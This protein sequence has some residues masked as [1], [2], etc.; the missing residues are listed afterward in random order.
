MRFHTGKVAATFKASKEK[1]GFRVACF[2]DAAARF[3]AWQTGTGCSNHGQHPGRGNTPIG[4]P[5][6][7]P[8]P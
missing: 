2:D 3:G 8:G 5:A 7:S 1:V 6:E 4:L